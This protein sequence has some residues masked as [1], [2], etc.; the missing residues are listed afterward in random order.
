MSFDLL[1]WPD[2]ADSSADE[3]AWESRF[4]WR[5]ILD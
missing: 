5:K 1:F 2:R 3:A 4:S